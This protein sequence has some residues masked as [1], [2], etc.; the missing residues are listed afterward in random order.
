MGNHAWRP[1]LVAIGAVALLLTVRANVVPSDFGVHGKNFTYGFHRKSSIDEWKEFKVKYQGKEYCRECHEEKVEENLTSPHKII[2]CENCH[3][4]AI[5]HPD[6]PEKLSIEVDR[7]LCLRCHAFLPY[8]Q[9][10]RADM[11]AV[12][13]IEHNPGENCISC[14]NPHHP[15]LEEMQ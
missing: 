15:N 7:L 13:P 14:H 12:D 2:Q 5:D 10:N 11:P 1:F 8:P 4:P 3:G 9:S 6:N